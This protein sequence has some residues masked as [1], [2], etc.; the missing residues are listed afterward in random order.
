[1]FRRPNEDDAPGEGNYNPIETWTL[2]RGFWDGAV[3]ID[4]GNSLKTW[5]PRHALFC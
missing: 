4:L 1:M 5:I 3:L 2:K